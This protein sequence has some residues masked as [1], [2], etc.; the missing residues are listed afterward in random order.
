MKTA[1]LA[2][3]MAAVLTGCSSY[4]PPK[5]EKWAQLA[6]GNRPGGA[7]RELSDP[8]PTTRRWAILRLAHAGDLSATELIAALLDQAK[9]PTAIVRATAAVGLRVLADE[10]A[11]PA[12]MT[13]LND[14]EPLVRADVTETIGCLGNASQATELA[15]VL[16]TDR[17]QR[18]RLQ[19]VIA[20]RR[21]AG[22]LAVPPLIVALDD[23]DE[24]VAFAAHQ[25]LMAMTGQSLPPSRARWEK[26][27]KAGAPSPVIKP[28]GG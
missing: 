26:W 14:P 3:L 6:L 17:D 12:L 4:G 25:G 19:A 5:G 21:T 15:R 10:R 24:S 23:A 13:A 20:L 1:L 8:S 22:E 11:L 2:L 16:H 28:H 27:L 18:V 9:E 7:R